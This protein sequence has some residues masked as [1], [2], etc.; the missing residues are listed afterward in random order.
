MMP[1]ISGAY[2]MRGESQRINIADGLGQELYTQAKLGTEFSEA[3]GNMTYAVSIR[4]Q[5]AHATWD[6]AGND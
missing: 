2:R 5:Y 4:N 3:I 6:R 1:T